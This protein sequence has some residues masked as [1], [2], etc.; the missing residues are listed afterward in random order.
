[1]GGGGSNQQEPAPA[2]P[3]APAG[4]DQQQQY[5]GYQQQQQGP[6]CQ[7]EMKQFLECAQTQHDISLC[8]GFNE[9]LRQCKLTN[10]E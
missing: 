8:S 5:A 3:A 7:L 6:A 9:A 10:G 2:P 1:M 4:Y